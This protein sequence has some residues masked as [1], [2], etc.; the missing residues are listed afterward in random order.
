LKVIVPVFVA[1]PTVSVLFPVAVIASL[2]VTENVLVLPT[3]VRFPFASAATMTE[4]RILAGPVTVKVDPV[5]LQVVPEVPVLPVEE[6]LS[7]CA[8][9]NALWQRQKMMM[10]ELRN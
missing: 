2:T 3:T 1:L 9:K 6:I 5:I 7:D 8:V 10:K 4:A